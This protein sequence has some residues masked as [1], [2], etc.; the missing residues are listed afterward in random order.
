[1]QLWVPDYLDYCEQQGYSPNTLLA[2]QQDLEQFYSILQGLGLAAHPLPIRTLTQYL[3]ALR[4]NGLKT[5]SILR[6]VSCLRSY[7]QWLIA[8]HGMPY[9][10]FFLLDLPKAPI[11]LPQVLSHHDVETLLNDTTINLSD[12]L[13]LELLYGCGLRISELLNLTLNQ[14]HLN[15]GYLRCLG[16]GQKERLVPLSAPSLSLIETIVALHQL[17]PNDPLLAEGDDKKRPSRRQLWGRIKVLGERIGKTISPHTFRHTFATHLLDGGADLRVVQELLGHA[18][19]ATTQHYTHISQA[20]VKAAHQKV[21]K[22]SKAN[23]L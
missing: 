2:Y 15:D 20:K 17:Q 5:R 6:K 23:G 13:L 21:F 12:R 14:I 4:Q 7:Y 3:K 18:D 19:I 8:Y 22:R 16:K 1:M 9:N 11:P 10:P